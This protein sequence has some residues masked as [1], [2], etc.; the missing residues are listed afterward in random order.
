M[1][2]LCFYGTL[3]HLLEA[4]PLASGRTGTH[5]VSWN[6]SRLQT[7]RLAV[8]SG[9]SLLCLAVELLGFWLLGNR[10]GSTVCILLGHLTIVKH[11]AGGYGTR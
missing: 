5:F 8:W 4:G 3:G 10:A 9:V 7:T 6:S 11:F 1:R 2:F